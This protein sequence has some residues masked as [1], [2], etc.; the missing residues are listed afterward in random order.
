MQN[1]KLYIYGLGGKFIPQGVYI[2]TNMVLA[3]LLAPSDFGIIGVLAIFFMIAET[4][5]DAGL[6]GSLINKKQITEIDC[7]TVFVFNLTV[8]HLMYVALF[9]AADSIESY[10][11]IAGLA[12]ITRV[13]GL[14]FVIN[15]W[16]LIV[17]TIIAKKLEFKKLMNLA[18]VSGLA[19]SASS[20]IFAALGF[21]VYALVAYQLVLALGRV[22]GAYI[23]HPMR[24]SFKFSLKSF[25]TLAPFGVYTTLILIIDNIY[26]NLL[27]ILF[28]KHLSMKAA[29]YFSQSKRIEES[30]TKTLVATIN[31]VAFPTLSRVK[32]SETFLIEANS[33]YK[34]ICLLLF[35]LLIIISVY[36]KEMI[37]LL[38]GNEWIEAAQYLSFLIY[39]GFFMV[40]ESLYRNFIKSLGDVGKLM[41]Y[42]VYKRVIGFILIF[43]SLIM[44]IELVLYAYVF[45]A[46]IAFLL[47]LYLFC[48]LANEKISTHISKSISYILPSILYVLCINIADN[49]LHISLHYSIAFSVLFEGLY[50]TLIL[51]KV[52]N[53]NLLYHLR[54]ILNRK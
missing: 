52:Y 9:F 53:I 3:R 36:S 38:F 44:S 54:K 8:S 10:F 49:K 5:M 40:M 48:R 16:G 12:T 41:I 27:T 46:A 19:A 6:G 22:V 4:M 43:S 20:I 29:G 37:V 32:G 23:I 2:L 33:L 45:S 15:S 1:L 21:G 13:I 47:N 28:G 30:A 51:P 18:I 26:E 7:S 25:K 39:A 24:L 31:N 11:N 50:Y 34:T 14:V 35:P 17:N 42:T